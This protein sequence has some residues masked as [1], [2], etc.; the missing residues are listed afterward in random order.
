MCKSTKPTSDFR[1]GPETVRARLF[2][3]ALSPKTVQIFCFTATRPQYPTSGPLH[4]SS[5]SALTVWRRLTQVLGCRPFRQDLADP[6]PMRL[7]PERLPLSAVRSSRSHRF[8]FGRGGGDR[9]LSR[10]RPYAC[11]GG[12]AGVRPWRSMISINFALSGGP[13]AA[14]FIRSRASRKYCGPM[15]AGVTAQST[16]TSSVPLLSN[17]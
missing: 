4:G 17:R 7:L 2:C 3:I 10:R 14:A 12:G 8:T 16:F 1:G 9:L 15:A 6:V 5:M 11:G 13:P